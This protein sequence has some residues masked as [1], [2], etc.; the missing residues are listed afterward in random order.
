[1]FLNSLNAIKHIVYKHS[2]TLAGPKLKNYVL[3]E[4]LQI[5]LLQ[6]C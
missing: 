5:Y 6:S 4:G 2:N 1:M 3:A